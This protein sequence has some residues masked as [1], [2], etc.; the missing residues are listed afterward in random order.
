MSVVFDGAEFLA[1]G[2]GGVL[3]RSSN[4]VS[5]AAAGKP[6]SETEAS[7]AAGSDWLYSAVLGDNAVLAVGL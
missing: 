6:V 3:L 1:L 5:W 2:E 4:G 7:G